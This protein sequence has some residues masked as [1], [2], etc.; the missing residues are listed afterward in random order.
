VYF[1]GAVNLSKV[2]FLGCG[3]LEEIYAPKATA[4]GEQFASSSKLRS[5]TLGK[6]PP[7]LS[8]MA[9]DK[10]T[11]ISS[12]TIH[13]PYGTSVDDPT[14]GYGKWYDDNRSRIPFLITF[15]VDDEAD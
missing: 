6:T 13:V 15:V 12:L 1:P 2:A 3:N 11:S 4:F 5:I 9:F 7:G 10:L 14:K 8:S